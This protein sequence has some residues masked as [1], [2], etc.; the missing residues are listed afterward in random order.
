MRRALINSIGWHSGK[1]VCVAVGIHLQYFHLHPRVNPSADD[2]RLFYNGS[3]QA[4][5][6]PVDN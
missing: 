6:L 2:L 1:N 4:V 5:I 3:V